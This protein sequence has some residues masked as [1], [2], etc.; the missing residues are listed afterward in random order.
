MPTALARTTRKVLTT[1][2]IAAAVTGLSL[3]TG[4]T[5]GATTLQA[6]SC[7][8]PVTGQIGD[9]VAVHGSSLKELVRRGAN[10]AGTLAIGKW[11]AND[12]EKAGLLPVGT[13]PD[14]ATGTVKGEAIGTVAADKLREMGSWG[15]G[16]D[17]EKTLANIKRKIAG[18]CGFSVRAANYVAPTTPAT[19]Q[20]AGRAD[21]S[22]AAPSSPGTPGTAQPGGG[23]PATGSGTG[24][25]APRDYSGIPSVTPPN[26]GIAVPPD[27]RYPP[28]SGTPG[29][30]PEFGILGAEGP[31]AGESPDVR[32]AGNA[33]A[34]AA[35]EAP[36]NVQLPMLLAVV[37][38][39]GVTAALVRTWVLRRVS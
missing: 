13:V 17:R 22:G 27:L 18:S 26:A 9:T 36:G 38:L 23:I 2:A 25:A 32:N 19:Q 28:P 37:A 34:L 35:G 7:S 10:E 39:A 3:V 6:D 8:S 4:G 1:T 33:D 5:A 15:L 24:Y 21:S 14:A 12:I 16:V 20:P 29:Q 30:T 11:A 31:A